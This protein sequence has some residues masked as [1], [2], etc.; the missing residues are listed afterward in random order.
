MSISLHVHGFGPLPGFDGAAG[1]QLRMVAILDIVSQ[2]GEQVCE[3]QGAFPLRW[4]LQGALVGHP[5]FYFP[6]YFGN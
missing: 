4:G 3:V 2:P 6:Y 5:L 1:R